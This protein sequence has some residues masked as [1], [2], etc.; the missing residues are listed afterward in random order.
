ML[1]Q[2]DL[3]ESIAK[4]LKS[5]EK[6]WDVRNIVLRIYCFDEVIRT[7]VHLKS[8]GLKNENILKDEACGV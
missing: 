1:S 3:F 7:H 8:V 5:W 2:P 6:F 4:T